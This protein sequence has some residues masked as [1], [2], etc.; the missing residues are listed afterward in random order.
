M[1]E[2]I[3]VQIGI[4]LQ[5]VHDKVNESL[6]DLFLLVTRECPVCNV[7]WVAVSTG[8]RIAKQILQTAFTRERITLQVEENVTR[9][10]LRQN[11][12][13]K[14]G[15][16]REKL[17]NHGSGLAT[18]DLDTRLLA[19]PLVGNRSALFNSIVRLGVRPSM[20]CANGCRHHGRSR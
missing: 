19:N 18:L 16:H 8:E 10:W 14:A 1:R 7:S 9:R 15:H 2:V 13:T 3:D 5:P 20:L 12:Q 4:L 11:R 6:E 17:V